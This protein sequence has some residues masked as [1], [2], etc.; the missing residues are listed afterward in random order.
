MGGETGL[1]IGEVARRAGVRASAL[2]YYESVGLLRAPRRAAGRRAYE[3]EVLDTLRVVR[4]A[5]DAGFSLAEIRLLL[6]GFAQSTPASKRWRPLAERKLR[7]VTAH[8]E[9]ARRMQ[10][11]LE[12][13]LACECGELADCVRPRLVRIAPVTRAC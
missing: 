13:L 5:R 1:T 12:G 10:R 7:D 4:L 6:H 3:A 8:I 9:R 11:L 2:R